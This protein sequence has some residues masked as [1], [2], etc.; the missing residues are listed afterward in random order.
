MIYKDNKA[1]ID[2]I[3]DSKPMTHSQHI[4]VQYF[5]IQEWQNHGDLEM[6]HIPGVI[7]PVDDKTKA[8]S[9]ILHSKHSCHAM[10]HYG[11]PN[12]GRE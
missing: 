7:N 10:G 2:M 12:M 3:N 11:S 9:W 8:L 1:A 6:K 4:N 5:A